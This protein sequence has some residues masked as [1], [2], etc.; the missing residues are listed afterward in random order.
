MEEEVAGNK[1]GQKRNLCLERRTGR[2]SSSNEWT[3]RDWRGGLKGKDYVSAEEHCCCGRENH[4]ISKG[5][6]SRGGREEVEP[7]WASGGGSWGGGD[8]GPGQPGGWGARRLKEAP[9]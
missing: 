8:V 1:G 5:G 2:L 4:V 7:A 9:A 6:A 3:N